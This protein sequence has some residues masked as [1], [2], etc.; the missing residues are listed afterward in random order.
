MINFIPEE[1]LKIIMFSVVIIQVH[2]RWILKAISIQHKII[3]E[4]R[5]MES[6]I[7]SHAGYLLRKMRYCCSHRYSWY[8]V[9]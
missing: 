6:P 3:M 1:S 2:K 8:S 7:K 9:S 4:I 5:T